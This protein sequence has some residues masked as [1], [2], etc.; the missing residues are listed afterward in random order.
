MKSVRE[1]LGDP[2]SYAFNDTV[3]AYRIMKFLGVGKEN[4][5]LIFL[6]D[7]KLELVKEVRIHKKC[8]Y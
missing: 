2:D 8:C 3:F 1:E 4:W 5:H 7:E 6:P